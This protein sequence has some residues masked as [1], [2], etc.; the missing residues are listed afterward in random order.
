MARNG[1]D[2]REAVLYK[3]QDVLNKPRVSAY[4]PQSLVEVVRHLLSVAYDE[5][6]LDKLL[7]KDSGP[8]SWWLEDIDYNFATQKLQR[9]VDIL[10]D[11][12]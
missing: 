1:Y 4:T 8:R 9:V 6:K 12:P 3:V 11:E 2:V 5:R 7:H 10:S